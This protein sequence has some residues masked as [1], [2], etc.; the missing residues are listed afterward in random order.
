MPRIITREPMTSPVPA[1]MY[2][3]AIADIEE[4]FEVET[5]WGEKDQLIVSF[6]L[7]AP[8][9]PFTLRKR[10]N[11]SIHEKSGFYKLVA[12]VTGKPPSNEFD[13]DNLVGVDCRL[14]VTHAKDDNGNTWARIESVLPE[15]GKMHSEANDVG[16]GNVN[17]KRG[18]PAS[19]ANAI[20][21]TSR[22]SNVKLSV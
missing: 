2:G 13:I 20:H 22:Y 8:G 17:K 21:G 5:P 15:E 1:G 10:Y 6:E 11:R 9:G 18:T 19:A 3:A 16:L 7:D 4:A 14:V 12:S